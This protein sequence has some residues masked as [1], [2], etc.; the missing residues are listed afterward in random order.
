MEGGREV[1]HWSRH[2]DHNL[3]RT[4]SAQK[5]EGWLPTCPGVAL[6]GAGQDCRRARTPR[7]LRKAGHLRNRRTPD[8]FVLLNLR[9]S[10]G[11]PEATA[12]M[13][14][15][16]IGRL[17]SHAER[18][19]ATH[20]DPL[21]P[22]TAELAK[23]KTRRRRT[24]SICH[25]CRETTLGPTSASTRQ[26]G[27]CPGSRHKQVPHELC[28]NKRVHESAAWGSNLPAV[29]RYV[30]QRIHDGSCGRS[31]IS[32][33]DIPLLPITYEEEDSCK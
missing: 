8:Y 2:G 9:A 22:D 31:A 25:A 33:L 21:G 15:I 26:I 10:L 23:E 12:Y 30:P 17:L 18:G 19:T 32:A 3:Y 5:S 6:P 13:Q 11:G 7:L 29:F 4:G 24:E 16:H 28:S 20:D 14:S 1:V 27:R